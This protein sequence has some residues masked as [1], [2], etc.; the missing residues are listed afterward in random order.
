MNR[1]QREKNR[2]SATLLLGSA[3][4]GRVTCPN[5]CGEGPHF[6]PPCL[7]DPGFF[8]CGTDSR[9]MKAQLNG[10]VFGRYMYEGA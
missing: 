5:C 10:R 6:V 7:G 4:V 9:A 2:Q 1:K 8:I 3:R